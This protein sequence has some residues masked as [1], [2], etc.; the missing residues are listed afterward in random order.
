MAKTR[1]QKESE[2]R[3]AADGLR[4]ATAVVF[5]DMASLKVEHSTK[6]RRLAEKDQV[7]IKSLKRTLLRQALKEAGLDAVPA[8]QLIGS[9]S[10][11]LGAG[12]Q[13]APAKAAAAFRKEQESVKILGGVM[14]GVWMTAD[15]IKAL[16]MLPSKQELLAKLVGSINAPISGLVNVLAGN[17]RGLVNALNSIKD[18]KAS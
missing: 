3:T 12:D 10:V 1:V 4:G 16:A 11:L 8:D 7:K 13:V 18:A 2:V 5:A 9:I 6:F 14:D 15:Q 17:L